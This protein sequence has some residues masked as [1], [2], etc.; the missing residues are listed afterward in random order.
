MTLYLDYAATTPLDPR[1][2]DLMAELLRDGDACA[3]PASDHAPGRR[4]AALVERA[5]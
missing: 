1:V 4:A 5:R 2:A 3:N